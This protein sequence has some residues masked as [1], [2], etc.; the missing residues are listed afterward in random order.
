MPS[1]Q[2]PQYHPSVKTKTVLTAQKRIPAPAPQVFGP[3]FNLA[4]RVKWMD[5]VKGIEMVSK[6]L[7]NRIGTRHR[8]VFSPEKNYI[9]VTEYARLSPQEAELVEL[10]EKKQ[11]G[12]RYRVQSITD[13]ESNVVID[14]LLRNNAFLLAYFNLFEKKKQQ[15]SIVRSLDN[16]YNLCTGAIS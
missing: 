10:D 4:E 7:I 11:G 16:L 9:I 2:L 14:F 15:Q 8:C 6:H 3:I 1:V 13:T 12:L 5:G